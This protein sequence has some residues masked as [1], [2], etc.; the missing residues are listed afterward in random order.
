MGCSYGYLLFTC[1]EQCLLVDV[2]TGSM[3]KPPKF[4]CSDHCQIHY[5]ILM[6]PLS[7][8]NSSLL[9]FSRKSVFQWQ[10][11]ANYWTEHP[12]VAECIRQ[13]VSFKG[14][15]FAM[16]SHQKLNIISLAPQLDMQELPVVWGEDMVAGLC[17][18]SWLV[19][20]GDMLL[21]VDIVG[22]VPKKFRTV[23]N[24]FQM[25]SNLRNSK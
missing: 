25:I 5:G 8:P 4:Q 11:G 24:L 22:L 3:V 6:A 7:S 20:C 10:V 21:V 2:Y 16:N 15:M 18:R 12:L 1:G 9:L 19:V 13:I 17:K 14:Q 23:W